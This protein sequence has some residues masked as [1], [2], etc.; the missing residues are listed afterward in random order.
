[1]L[2]NSKHYHIINPDIK[3]KE[4]NIC[5]CCL[6]KAKNCTTSWINATEEKEDG[7]FKI[8]SSIY[9]QDQQGR[10]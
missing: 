7:K 10:E 5:W 8:L 6:Y 9:L 2:N 3:M 1:M 4:M